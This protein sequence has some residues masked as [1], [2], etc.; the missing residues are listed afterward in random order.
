MFHATGSVL[1]VLFVLLLVAI[2]VVLTLE[3]RHERAHLEDLRRIEQETEA[4]DNA[5]FY[6]IERFRNDFDHPCQAG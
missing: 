2:V 6:N 1:V 3:V 5:L 4:N